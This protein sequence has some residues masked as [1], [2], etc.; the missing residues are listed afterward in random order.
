VFAIFSHFQLSLIFENK[1]GAY[2]AGILSKGRLLVL[3]ANFRLRDW[4]RQ[5]P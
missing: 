1:D 5:T 4:L 3:N 2:L